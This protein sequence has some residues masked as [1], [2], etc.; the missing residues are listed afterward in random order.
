MYLKS[1]LELQQ[2]VRELEN[3]VSDISENIQEIYSDIDEMRNERQNTDVDYSKIEILADNISFGK[4]PIQKLEDGK[5]C[6]IY[7]EMLLNIVRLDKDEE[8]TLNRL[9]F[10]QWLQK[11]SRIDWSLEDLYKDCFTIKA[12]SFHEMI[13]LL[14]NKYYEC[15]I[16]DSLMI[17]NIEGVAKP[18]IYEYI[19]GLVSILGIDKER[20]SLLALVSKTALCQNIG[21]MKKK[22]MDE[23][24]KVAKGYKH[25]IRAD[26]LEDG[27]KSL[28]QIVVEL[29]DSEVKNFKWKV[30]QRQE[31]KKND[32]IAT[33]SRATKRR[34]FSYR[35]NYVTEEIVAPANG[36]IFQ[37]RDKCVNFGVL[38]HENDNKD[39]IKAWVKARR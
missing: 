10:I 33:Y 39:S 28:R 34:G 23:F 27:I 30:K 35:T 19:V 3:K 18:E 9:V 4:H 7:I 11:E 25:Y 6:Q 5:A 1:L 21:R 2:S 15:F 31:I 29:A 32:V 14:P 20:F 26:I 38:A 22:D 16:V 37:F 13:T 36:T 8:I 12:D 17:A 24:Q